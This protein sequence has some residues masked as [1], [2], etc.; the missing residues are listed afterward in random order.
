LFL[1]ALSDGG[2]S[3]F[4][5]LL[6]VTISVIAMLDNGLEATAITEFAGPFWTGRAL[7]IQNTT[8]R[9]MAAAGPPLFGA[10]IGAFEK[11]P[12][13]PPA[14]AL[15]GLFPLAAVPLVAIDRRGGSG[16][17]PCRAS[18]AVPSKEFRG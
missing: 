9:V 12:A 10:L 11:A 18:E 2:N 6:M 1:L 7:G 5:V 15:C 3:R 14:W 16:D 13:Y 8:Q 17:H 4:D